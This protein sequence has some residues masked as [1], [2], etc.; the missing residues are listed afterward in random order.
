[1]NIISLAA[2]N[3]QMTFIVIFALFTLA[4]LGAIW[5]GLKNYL[6]EKV[7]IKDVFKDKNRLMLLGV[8]G[9][10][11]SFTI[12]ATLLGL[13]LGN[14]D[15]PALALT[16]I[17]SFLFAT[18]LLSFVL[19]FAIHFYKLNPAKFNQKISFLVVVISGILSFIT[20]FMMLD[21]FVYLDII[22]FPLMSKIYFNVETG[23]GIAFYAL[24]ILAGALLSLALSDHEMYK[25]YKRHGML[26]SVFYVAFPAGIVGARIWFVI[27]DWY[28]FANDPIRMFYIW[29]G[30][31]AIMGGAILG[32]IA[33]VL[34]V[35]F[36]KK[37]INILFAADVIVP[38]ILLAQAVGR[39]GNFFNQE[40]YG[41]AV[42]NLDA[43]FFLPAFV[44]ENMFI[45]GSYRVP[46][47]F[48]ES[49]TNIAGYFAIRYGVGHG[50]KKYRQPLDMAFSY[51]IWYGLTRVIMEPLRDS[52][53]NMGTDGQWSYIWGYVMMIGGV[54]LIVGNHIYNH[55]QTKKLATNQ[56]GEEGQIK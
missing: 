53:Y 40:V 47:F 25:K 13:S 6:S 8:I 46:L 1:M 20:L 39:W 15:G 43:Y 14:G 36:K 49:M 2:T 3:V 16:I 51:L 44:K 26:E 32:I 17:G 24:F 45:E 11:I 33:G 42:S 31:L 48:I 23:Q 29:E 52:T 4:S 38:T 55:Y 56:N 7:A 41:A 28:R 50:L 54:L 18:I 22:T 27:G 21:G 9:A 35:K 37:E 12:L 34:F 30:G 19:S 10:L 5:F